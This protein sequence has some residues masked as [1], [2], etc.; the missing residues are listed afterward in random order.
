M[1][2]LSAG[3]LLSFV[4]IALNYSVSKY[5]RR[6]GFPAEPCRSAAMTVSAVLGASDF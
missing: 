5:G 6:G 4:R 3:M 2:F 1:G